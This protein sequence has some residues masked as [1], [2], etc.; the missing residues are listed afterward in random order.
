MWQVVS[1]L[2]HS[3]G[4]LHA[5]PVSGSGGISLCEFQLFKKNIL[6]EETNYSPQ[7]SP[8]FPVW[9]PNKRGS[10]IQQW[11]R[12]VSLLFLAEKLA[13]WSEL[14]SLPFVWFITCNP[15]SYHIVLHSY[16]IFSKL[17]IPPYL[18]CALCNSSPSSSPPPR[19][20]KGGGGEAMLL[21]VQSTK[22]WHIHISR[23]LFYWSLLLGQIG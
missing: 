1:V 20:R 7:K 4:E 10:I 13:I 12:R 11:G 22:P 6:W 8:V 9:F 18:G 17:I 2:K 14:L 16:I 5:F 15:F 21:V 3:P 23:I 19:K